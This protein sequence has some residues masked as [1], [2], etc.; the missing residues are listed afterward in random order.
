MLLALNIFLLLTAYYVLKPV[1][2]ALILG[3]GSAEL[4]SYMSA[5]MVGVLA[6][7]VPLYGRLA[8][9]VPRR[10]L[11][12]IV[13]ALFA[14]C[15][16]LFYGLGQ[17]GVPLGMVFFVWIGVFSV[18]I[19]AQFWGFANDLYTKDEGERLFPIVGFGASLGAVLGAV[20]AG[21]LIVPLGLDQLMLVGAGLLIVQVLLTNYVDTRERARSQAQPARTPETRT[22]TDLTP[23]KTGGK[24]K[25]VGAFGMVFGTPYLLMIGL[26]LMCLNW[27]N[28]T[29]EYILGSV[30]EDVAREAVAAGTAGGV[31]VEEYIGQFYSQFF[32]V[33]NVAGVL[34]QLFLVSRIIKYIGVRF[35]VMVLPCIALGAYNVLAFFPVLAAIRW[36]KT[37]ENATDYSLNN[38]VRNMLFL[39]CTREQKYGAKQV[40]DSFFHRIGDV[41]SAV[42]VFVG[43]TY[44]ALGGSGFAGFNMLVVSGWLVLSFYIGREYRQLAAVGA[45]PGSRLISLRA[46]AVLPAPPTGR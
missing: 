7:V 31:S 16:V 43:T 1:R 14:G 39:P 15:L 46:S 3:Q 13:T 11:I 25:S 35:G 34:I 5:G 32:F 20:V 42:L 21:W 27:V 45:A 24:M 22:E 44:L 36:A 8:S 19:V 4:K 23:A 2:E 17:L 26:M 12:N 41:L 33:V 6:I 30:I 18:M 10:R 9:R 37:A 28:T 38:T 40:I 29:G